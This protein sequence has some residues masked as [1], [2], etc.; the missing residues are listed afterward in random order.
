MSEIK[1]RH[2]RFGLTHPTW[3]APECFYYDS[4]AE[5]E[6]AMRRTYG[7]DSGHLVVG[8]WPTTHTKDDE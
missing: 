6:A 1:L 5:A 8:I 2:K 3:D 4:A 7:D